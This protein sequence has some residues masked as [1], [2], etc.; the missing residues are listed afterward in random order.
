MKILVEPG[1]PA[2]P[3]RSDSA[4]QEVQPRRSNHDGAALFAC[5]TAHRRARRRPCR[6]RIQLTH[7]MLRHAGHGVDVGAAAARLVG[8]G[9]AL[10]AAWRVV[11]TPISRCA[12][13]PSAN[14]SSAVPATPS[15]QAAPG[16][17]VQCA[18]YRWELQRYVR[19]TQFAGAPRKDGFA[20]AVL[21][22]RRDGVDLV[23]P[24]N[25]DFDGI[26]RHTLGE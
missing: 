1:G 18:W 11:D 24:R 7:R 12:P 10:R 14:A 6:L 26:E 13:R 20:A 5:A 8:V 9:L 23:E 15:P 2:V 17:G 16:S 3:R 19:R 25:A 22:D 21:V 4:V